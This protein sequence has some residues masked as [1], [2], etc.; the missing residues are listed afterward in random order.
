[1][2]VHLFA[3]A[4]MLVNLVIRPVLASEISS[5]TLFELANQVR[6]KH[7]LPSLNY[8]IPLEQAAVAKAKDMLTSGY[9]DHFGPSGETPWQFMEQAGYHYLYGGENLAVGFI[10]ADEMVNAW[11]ASPTHRQN[12]LEEQFSDIGIAVVPVLADGL[13]DLIVVQMFG[14]L[15]D[16]TGGNDELTQYVNSLLGVGD[17]V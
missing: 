14:S 9:F 16:E 2:V 4:I 7:N 3:I 12:L 8:S 1:M 10:G 6:E 5:P 15:A 13:P 17:G 11:L